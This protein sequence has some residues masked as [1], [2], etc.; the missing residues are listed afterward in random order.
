[1]LIPMKRNSY[2][3]L[4]IMTLMISPV[5]AYA[6]ICDNETTIHKLLTQT[7]KY[8]E[9]GHYACRA[10]PAEAGFSMLAV[11]QFVQDQSIDAPDGHYLMHLYKINDQK[12]NVVA[13]YH[14]PASYVSDAV[15]LTG[16]QLDTAAYRLN[17]KQRALGLRI[18]YRNGSQVF[19]YAPVHLNLYNFEKKQKILSELPVELYRGENDMHCKNQWEEQNAVLQMLNQKTKGYADIRVNMTRKHYAT[20]AV[21]GQCKDLPTK[22]DSKSFTLKYD[23]KQ[24]QVPK[25]LREFSQ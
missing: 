17:P 15:A 24:Y 8:A 19:P 21:Q 16:I 11:A 18:E 9:Y 12:Q 23:G 1:M 2:Q 3:C 10:L 14:D 25:A 20:H 22:E 6:S 4:A 13:S 7:G 5:F